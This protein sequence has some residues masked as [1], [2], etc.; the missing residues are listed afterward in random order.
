MRFSHF[1]TV[2]LFLFALFSISCGK[3]DPVAEA[4][5]STRNRADLIRDWEVLRS[6]GDIELDY[7]K[8]Y[9]GKGT[10]M[11][12]MAGA[13][14]VKFGGNIPIDI[15]KCFELSPKEE[16]ILLIYFEPFPNWGKWARKIVVASTREEKFNTPRP[17]NL[18]FIDFDVLEAYVKDKSVRGISYEILREKEK[19]AKAKGFRVHSYTVGGEYRYSN[20]TLT[21]NEAQ[22]LTL[23][24]KVSETNSNSA[25]RAQN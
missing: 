20:K 2:L 9:G 14:A 17:D 7:N 18:E 21:I 3:N 25:C 1:L 16:E 5:K 6:L 19:V 11:Y 22:L 4:I 13:S 24:D 23:P 12:P 15:L 8:L 10:P